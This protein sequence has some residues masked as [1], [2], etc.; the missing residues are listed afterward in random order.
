M[1]HPL[2]GAHRLPRT[3]RNGTPV[4]VQDAHRIAGM[5]QQPGDKRGLARAGTSR[6]HHSPPVST[7]AHG[8]RASV[9][10]HHVVPGHRRADPPHADLDQPVRAESER[11]HRRLAPRP[12]SR[13]VPALCTTVGTCWPG[14]RVQRGVRFLPAP[15]R[16]PV[17]GEHAAEPVT[18]RDESDDHP[19]PWHCDRRQRPAGQAEPRHHVAQGGPGLTYR[20][21]RAVVANAPHAPSIYGWPSAPAPP[22]SNHPQAFGPPSP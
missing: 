20:R 16:A 4:I 6:D 10:E 9:Q 13:P 14:Q 12:P 7:H 15:G 8:Q 3:E 5:P 11:E 18:V 17:G 19:P 1:Q 21:Q 22:F 2:P